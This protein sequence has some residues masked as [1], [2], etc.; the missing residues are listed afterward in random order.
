M[1]RRT[2]RKRSQTLS[3]VTHQK[4]IG[5]GR[6]F[7]TVNSDDDGAFETFVRTAGHG[8]CESLNEGIGR[9][10]SLALRYGIPKEEIV[11]QLRRVRC[12]SC[13]RAKERDGSEVNVK[14]CPDAI[15]MALEE[16]ETGESPEKGRD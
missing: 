5:C 7:V 15:G 4:E 11:K 14:S 10:V 6:L 3:G 8:G 2:K 9:M 16:T 1:T 12:M 13:V